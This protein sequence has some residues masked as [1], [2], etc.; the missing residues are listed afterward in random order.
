VPKIEE[1]TLKFIGA[2]EHL[3]KEGKLPGYGELGV[4]MGIK[5]R[6]TISEIL[7]KRQN[8]Q[9]DSW[10]KFKTH[11]GFT[12]KSEISDREYF[13]A[14]H[15]RP[16]VA[17]S[18]K[19]RMELGEGEVWNMYIKE[20]QEKS[21]ILK[22]QV[23][24]LQRVIESNLIEISSTQKDLQ[25]QMVASVRRSAERFVNDDP[26]KTKAELDRISKYAAQVRV[27]GASKGIPA[28]EGS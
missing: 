11:F 15:F 14:E 20:L 26:K 21:Q 27:P 16:L 17:G 7:A 23:Q 1:R 24:F 22:D 28:H 9:P 8:I 25:A 6:S 3:R 4:I 13:S 2:I 19:E 18:K 12:E 5:S 10:E